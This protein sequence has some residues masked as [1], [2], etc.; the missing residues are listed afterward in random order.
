MLTTS[1]RK[2][3]RN[4]VD[5]SSK[6]LARYWCKHLKKSKPEIEAAIAKVGNNAETLMK[7][8]SRVAGDSGSRLI[9]L[10]SSRQ[11]HMPWRDKALLGTKASQFSKENRLGY[12]PFQ[13]PMSNFGLCRILYCRA[14]QKRESHCSVDS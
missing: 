13:L 7:E 9:V 10:R 8:L 5:I 6:E 14:T 11:Q 3:A 1:S 4:L 12:A 2:R